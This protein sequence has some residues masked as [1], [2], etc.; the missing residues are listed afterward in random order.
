M[1]MKRNVAL[2]GNIEGK[3]RIK[4]VKTFKAES[5][6]ELKEYVE[7]YVIENREFIGFIDDIEELEEENKK[8]LENFINLNN[9]IGFKNYLNL[10][11]RKNLGSVREGII[12]NKEFK[13]LQYIND[14]INY[15]EVN[16]LSEKFILTYSIGLED[17]NKYSLIELKLYDLKENLIGEAIE[18][19]DNKGNTLGYTITNDK[20][21]SYKNWY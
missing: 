2:V 9:R 17:D 4:A 20:K 21:L 10:F 8:R 1:L 5:L 3:E 19:F 12:L 14:S 6:K 7:N 18:I 16:N 15:I 13:T 11:F